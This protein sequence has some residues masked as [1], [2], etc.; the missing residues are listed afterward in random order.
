MFEGEAMSISKKL[1]MMAVAVLFLSFSFPVLAQW[2]GY[3][4]YGNGYYYGY[5]P[6]PY[7]PRYYG[8]DHGRWDGR[9]WHGGR[10]G[11]YED[12]RGRWDGH[13]WH[14]GRWGHDD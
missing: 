6:V 9:D 4:G 8:R 5:G 2:G 7:G 12:E 10:W 3:G 14:G 11:H 13:D 1:V